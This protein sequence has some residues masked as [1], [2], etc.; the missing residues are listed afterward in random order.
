MNPHILRKRC[1]KIMSKKRLE[2]GFIRRT[3]LYGSAGICGIIV[4]AAV[5]F[6]I[7]SASLP[8]PIVV[9]NMLAYSSGTLTS[10]SINKKFSFRSKTHRLSLR[11]FYLT[12]V[13]GMIL[14]SAILFVLTQASLG[15]IYA[16]IIATITAVMMQY[17]VNT[18]F[19]LVLNQEK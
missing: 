14:S 12:S 8:L 7:G 18:Q 2:Y 19:S 3:F 11:R 16:K 6:S 1:N 4:D 15:I 17:A 13:V 10:F 5:F 9:L